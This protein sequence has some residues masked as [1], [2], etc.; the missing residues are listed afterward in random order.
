MKSI[1]I[2]Q[3]GSPKYLSIQEVPKPKIQDDEVLIQVNSSCVSTADTMMRKGEPKFAR[4]FLGLKRPRQNR[5]GTGFSGRII[6]LGKGVTNLQL[7]DVVFGLT[8]TQ[9]GANSEFI[10]LKA[11]GLI[12]HKPVF[13]SHHQ[14]A[15]MC[16]GVT[17]SMNFLTRL[18]KPKSSQRIL[19]HGATGSLGMAAI[20]IAKSQGLEVIATCSSDQFEK[21]KNLGADFCI[22]YKSN[23]YLEQI[24]KL[25][26]VV[27]IY[28]T[29]GKMDHKELKSILPSKGIYLTPVL[30]MNVICN[31]MNPFTRLNVKFSATGLLKAKEFNLF[32]QQSL[33]LIKKEEVQ[34]VMDKIFSYEEFQEAHEYVDS[35]RKKGNVCLDHGHEI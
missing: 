23:D 9:F 32:I 26:R 24:K 22:N 13:L 14:A 21:V 30:S 10:Q 18:I 12:W 31:W 8:A 7:G 33:K 34:V 19:I 2:E 15:C 17:T 28:D 3:Y 29:V 1:I 25:D 11:S 20:G 35:G 4:L 27:Y 5:I 6:Q 16:D